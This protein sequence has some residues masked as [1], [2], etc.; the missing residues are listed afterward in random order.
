MVGVRSIRIAMAAFLVALVSVVVFAAR[1]ASAALTN[2]TGG[3]DLSRNLVSATCTETTQTNWFL[4]VDCEGPR[5][6]TTI[7]G[8]LQF[9]PG[10]ATSIA[11]CPNG[12][13]IGASR[14]VE[15]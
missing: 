10:M 15:L 2:C 8:S 7:N 14:L 12:T 13:E 3:A 5:K 6:I 11:I 4:Q 1:P 9:G